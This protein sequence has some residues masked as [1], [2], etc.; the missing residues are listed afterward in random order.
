MIWLLDTNTIIYAQY[1][2]GR[3]RDRLDEASKKGRVVTSVLVIAE[4]F[5]GAAKSS[6]PD[7]NRRKV[8][9]VVRAIDVLPITIGSAARFGTL[10]QELGSRGRVKADIDLHI[11]A[12]AIEQG[13]TLVTNDGAL[14]SGDIDGLASE[15]W[16]L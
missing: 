10:K 12:T 1:V 14:L 2:G 9:E 15:N 8:E 11:A 7:A 13:A 4:L 5:Y 3:V 16:I 6:R